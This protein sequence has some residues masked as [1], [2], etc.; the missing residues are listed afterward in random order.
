M[1]IFKIGDRVWMIRNFEEIYWKDKNNIPKGYIATSPM[2]K[3]ITQIV[4]NQDG[5]I[6]YGVKGG[7]FHESWIGV[8]VFKTEEDAK[9]AM[10]E[11]FKEVV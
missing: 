2:Q 5:S 6:S 8:D 3:K 10:K 1:N 7:H 4:T 9:I 11:K